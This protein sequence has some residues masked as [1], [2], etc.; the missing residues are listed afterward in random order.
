MRYKAM[1]NDG[2]RSSKID[3]IRTE[4][5]SKTFARSGFSAGLYPEARSVD[6][7]LDL[8]EVEFLA[9][10]YDDCL[11]SND[12]AEYGCY[13]EFH[14]SAFVRKRR[15]HVL[16]LEHLPSSKESGEQY[17]AAIDEMDPHGLYPA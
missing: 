11:A 15:G 12:A 4:L 13:D 10:P 7:H 9:C 14:G 2:G 6:T 16:L 5:R 1:K 8:D 3:T 17:L